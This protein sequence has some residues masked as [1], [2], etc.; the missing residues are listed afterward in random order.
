M[1]LAQHVQAAEQLDD[2]GHGLHGFP[3][4]ASQ[5]RS[6]GQPSS[7]TSGDTSML[8]RACSSP[9]FLFGGHRANP[10]CETA[11][12]GQTDDR[13]LH[14]KENPLSW[15]THK[16]PVAI[17]PLKLSNRNSVSGSKPKVVAGNGNV[18]PRR[19]LAA[20]RDD[21]T[22]AYAGDTDLYFMRQNEFWVRAVS[23]QIG[24][25]T[26]QA[27]LKTIGTADLTILVSRPIALAVSGE[28]IFPVPPNVRL[29][30]LDRGPHLD[31]REPDP[32]DPRRPSG[33]SRPDL[34]LHGPHEQG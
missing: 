28:T 32:G 27:L 9:G 17:E 29:H 3:S 11:P 22:I 25:T 16:W 21:G 26:L 15:P 33:G 12:K 4:S 10:S 5:L 30:F 1:L 18:K 2:L 19:I 23:A 8:A 34:R 7:S 14:H 24:T 20:T 6:C 31:W 13:L